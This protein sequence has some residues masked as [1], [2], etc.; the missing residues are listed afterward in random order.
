MA[1]EE[2]K[3]DRM[4]RVIPGRAPWILAMLGIIT[5]LSL[6]CIIDLRSGAPRLTLDPT[7]DSMIPKGSEEQRYFEHIKE[8][9]DSG[10][11]ILVAL[12]DKDIFTAAN[13]LSIKRITKRIKKLKQVDRVSSLSTALNIRSEDENL[14]VEPFFDKVPEDTQSL[15]DLR[16]RAL[17]DP[18]YAGNLV[19]L[20]GR[21][22]VLM[23]HLRDMPGQELIDSRID[24]Q[25]M[26]IA[27][28]ESGDAEVWVSG[29]TH[30]KAEISR[31]MLDDLTFVVPL[32][33]GVMA[34]IA[35]ISFRTIR[36]VVIPVL[37]VQLSII[38]TMAL[39][40]LTYGSLNMVTVAA[41]PILI[42][43]G[44]A[45][46][47]HVV[48]AYYDVLRE[49]RG[50][51][52]TKEEV[53]FAA[54]KQV[55]VPVIFTGITTAAGFFSLTMSPIGAIKQFGIFC[56]TGVL[57]S[58]ILSLSLGFAILRV[59]PLSKKVRT[60]SSHNIFDP[61]ID[62]IAFFDLRHRRSILALG[63]V[64]AM[65]SLLGMFQIQVR[66][67]VVGNF[68][69]D[70]FARKHFELVNEH[71]EGA[72]AFNVVL[73]TNYT[74]ALKEPANLRVIEELQAWIESQPEVGGTTSIV[75][76]IK[77]INKGF[78]DTAAD[79]FEIPESR[80]LVAQLILIGG[81]DEL[82]R[83]VDFDYQIA[84]VLVR[85]TA[86]DSSDVLALVERIEERLG[87]I[88][89]HI[90]G[91]V[92]GNTVL[93]SRTS[94]DIAL[95]QALSLSTAF[96]FIYVILALLF[97]S[98]ESGFFALIPNVLPVL[99]YFGILGWMDITLNTTTGL[100]ACLVLGIAVDDTIHLMAHFNSASKRHAD[101]RKGIVE[102]LHAVGRPV[103]ATTAA[104]CLGFLCLTL[105]ESLSQ[106]Q[107]G[108]LSAF[109]LAF[110]WLV[111]VVFTPAL[112]T[113]M[114]IVSLWD[115]LTLD[116]G[117]DPPRAIP[118]FAG[119]RHAQARIVALMTSLRSY[120]EGHE[121]FR[122]GD[123]GDEM[124]VVIEGELEASI[125]SQE[126]GR[127]IPLRT[128]QRGD[129][130]G[131]IGI[132]YGQRTADVRAVS[133]VRMLRLTQNNLTRLKRRYPRIGA[134]IYA[135]LSK[136]LA[137]RLATVTPRVR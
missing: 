63:A 97:T 22:S 6:T 28:E 16:R 14:R 84:N 76:Y 71:L 104:L 25:I 79:A 119:L 102:A 17:S 62:K 40:A 73:E 8:V 137:E 100:V 110:A 57:I 68:K 69:P 66:T 13:L 24:E 118:L 108:L 88:P 7:V 53:V 132:F 121:L 107:F 70:N 133:A 46:A 23:V 86:M 12:V 95:G 48:S 29:S 98:F 124:Y 123:K 116:L 94:D 127:P 31:I 126:D 5:F 136:V 93:I 65:V 27:E 59:L 92:T 61:F 81:N 9:F 38:W 39:V 115:V 36:G 51:D 120:P 96:L 4:L 10:E 33:F 111:D 64:V 134:Q 2:K 26:Q 77:T 50:K 72:N 122:V 82:D 117:E 130:I 74:D 11:S 113:R 41:P 75:D 55:A 20:D 125:P 35:F 19:S 43:V 15:A 34:L 112:V 47:I 105:S 103:T 60:S 101:E 87:E 44:F 78:H 114:H 80:E 135:N 32:S 1:H 3:I 83:F 21:V 85:T 90:Q 131:E 56:G 106:V 109:T 49:G 45:Y 89:R 54:L 99:F 18:I 52:P 30:I 67:E 58:M 91:K 37:T 42:V 128:L 129:V